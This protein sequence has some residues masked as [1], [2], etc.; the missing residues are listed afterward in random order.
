MKNKKYLF[1]DGSVNPQ[2]KIGYGGYLFLD[3]LKLSQ[4]TSNLIK[5]KKFQNTSSTKLE[6]ETLLWAF[7]DMASNSDSL[8]IYTDCQN[9]LSLLD[10][11]EKLTKS[12][13]LNGK[14]QL[15][16]NHILYQIFFKWIDRIECRFVKIKGHKQKDL[17]DEID[18]IFSMVD[19]ATREALRDDPFLKSSLI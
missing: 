8:V 3:K 12:D 1:T 13:Y 16:K 5:T 6:L 11:R 4:E 10:R 19:K 18:N 9:I 2:L 7:E 17:K 14:N 15:M